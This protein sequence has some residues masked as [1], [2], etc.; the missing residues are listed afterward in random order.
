[1]HTAS[2]TSVHKRRSEW[3]EEKK[4][5]QQKV[6]VLGEKKEIRHIWK[7]VQTSGGQWRK[8]QREGDMEESCNAIME[9]PN[10]RF[11]SM[12]SP[13]VP[14]LFLCLAVSHLMSFSLSQRGVWLWRHS[15]FWDAAVSRGRS[16]SLTLLLHFLVV[17]TWTCA[18]VFLVCHVTLP[19]LL[20]LYQTC[21]CVSFVCRQL[22]MYVAWL[23]GFT[24][25]QTGSQQEIC[26]ST[27]FFVLQF[28]LLRKEEKVCPVMELTGLTSLS[29]WI[30][31]QRTGDFREVLR[32]SQLGFLSKP[33]F[34][35]SLEVFT[36]RSCV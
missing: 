2:S 16:W 35:T 19:C 12:S 28:L 26:T 7:N 22:R 30:H 23:W 32:P 21:K 10:D 4:R 20:N 31:S 33:T 29:I 14:V 25:N 17:F 27:S 3:K 6:R 5:L 36:H 8:R 34:H 11:V 15:E 18:R 1:M 13:V 9:Q 24:C